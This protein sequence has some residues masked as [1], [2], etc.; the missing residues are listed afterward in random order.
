MTNN[1]AA[2]S[3]IDQQPTQQCCTSASVVVDFLNEHKDELVH[4]LA[5][6]QRL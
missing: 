5:L 2:A 6:P 4:F 3:I 1:P